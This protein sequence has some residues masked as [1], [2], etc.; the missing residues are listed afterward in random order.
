MDT[1]LTIRLNAEVIERA[2][3]Y[4]S[5][6]KISLSKLVESYLDNISKPK[7]ETSEDIQITPFVKSLMGTAGSLPDNYDFKKEYRDYLEKK[8][9]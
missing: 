7:T 3:I 8:Y 1:K 4:A 6:Q 5:E 9:Q 2:K